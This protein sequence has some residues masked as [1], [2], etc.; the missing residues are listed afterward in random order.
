MTPS[1]LLL[2]A[3]ILCVL[4]REAARDVE[5]KEPPVLP[6]GDTRLP[7][8]VMAS[9]GL[10]SPALA[11]RRAPHQRAT[12]RLGRLREVRRGIVLMTILGPC[13]SLEPPEPPR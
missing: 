10:P 13:R 3:L 9:R 11:P 5:P 7:P 12:S 4:Q 1:Q 8:R 6:R 2:P